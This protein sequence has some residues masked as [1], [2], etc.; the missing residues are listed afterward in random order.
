MLKV[1]VESA[2]KASARNPLETSRSQL[3]V[4]GHLSDTLRY[5]RRKTQ[6]DPYNP[7]KDLKTAETYDS[8]WF[9]SLAGKVY[10]QLEK[11][12]FRK[13]FSRVE[14]DARVL[15]CSCGT[16]CLAEALLEQGYEVTRIDLSPAMRE[17]AG[18]KL[19]RFGARFAHKV[20]D[21]RHLNDGA[22]RFTAALC[23]RVPVLFPIDEQIE[24]SKRLVSVSNGFVSL[25]HSL[26]KTCQRLLRKVKRLLHHQQPVTYP[27]TES[28]PAM[29]RAHGALRGQTISSDAASK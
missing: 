12:K 8:G 9:S 16:G 25:T 24:F 26:D 7:Y 14:R 20:S 4:S 10:D 29:S 15:D 3:I 1:V 11:Y 2:R 13:A 18:R 27:V 19:R 28:D 21:A 6:W 17:V 23:V 5:G 22:E